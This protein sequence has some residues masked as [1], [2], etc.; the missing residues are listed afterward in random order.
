MGV[1]AQN[2][3]KDYKIRVEAVGD[4]RTNVRLELNNYRT[5][6]MAISAEQKKALDKYMEVLRR[7]VAEASL[8]TRSAHQEMSTQLAQELSDQYVKLRHNVA[9]F[10]KATAAAYRSMATAHKQ[11]LIKGRK[12][13]MDEVTATRSAVR[14]DQAEAATIWANI[15]QLK[16]KNRMKK[17]PATSSRAAESAWEMAFPA[18]PSGPDDFKVIH[19]IGP[20]MAKHLYTA[21]ISS[22]AQLAASTPE[23]LRQVLGK[24]G[25]LAKVET[26]ITQAQDLIR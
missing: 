15:S 11:S 24:D 14:T 5:V 1:V 8:A 3:L 13:L 21:G 18:E 17:G 12:Q 26:W 2:I 22:F 10:L 23:Q 4:L 6:Q 9:T 16:Q 25:K 7:E 19:G 20:G